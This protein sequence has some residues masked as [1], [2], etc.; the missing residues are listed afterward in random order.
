MTMTTK[1][2]W[3]YDITDCDFQEIE[4]PAGAQPLCVQIQAGCA[5]LWALVEPDREMEIRHF[6][7]AGTGHI[8]QDNIRQYVGS[9]Q[10]LGGWLIFHLFEIDPPARP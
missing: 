2:V 6:R 5:Q 10:F 3:K 4:M 7:L 8:I 9:F 1:T